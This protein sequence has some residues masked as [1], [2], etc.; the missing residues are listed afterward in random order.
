MPKKLL[1]IPAN[2]IMGFLGVGKT[3]TI[4][5]LLKQKPENEKWAVLV[6]EFGKV[7]I[8]GAIFEAAG[9]TVKEIAGGCL[10][11]A[12]GLPFKVSVNRLLKEAR[13]D[14]LIIE[15]TG[16]GHPKKVLEM[17]ESEHLRDVL[18]LK[19]AICLV[20]PSKLRD[21]RYKNHKNF[22]DQM[23]LADLMIANK[24]DLADEK[25]LS[26]FD[27]QAQKYKPAKALIAHTTH[28][29][30]DI[31]WLDFP[32][33][34]NRQAFFPDAHRSQV[35]VANNDRDTTLINKANGF[36]SFG[37]VFSEQTC[38][39]YQRLIDLLTKLEAER[40]KGIFFTNKGWF[41]VNCVDGVFN[42]QPSS[43]SV[44]SKL[45]VI[46][47]ENKCRDILKELNQC[48]DKS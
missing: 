25:N 33:T 28:G 6:N 3:T 30:L 44:I 11:C 16:L 9:A 21:I 37:Y 24:V 39:D 23:A 41:I 27:E 7:G 1:Q 34:V 4:L 48:V 26:L 20:D 5:N 10:C 43:P 18:D 13:P 40:I 17:L 14:R 29:Q 22:I 12:V 38:F 32:R 8:D 46:V 47:F 35:F 42:C 45:E 31:A 15:P 19:A 36:Q 2:I